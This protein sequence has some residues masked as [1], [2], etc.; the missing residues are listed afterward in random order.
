MLKNTYCVSL[1]PAL[2]PAPPVTSS[3]NHFYLFLSV[4][5]HRLFML[6]IQIIFPSFY[7][8]SSIILIPF[9]ALLFSLKVCLLETFPA[10]VKAECYASMYYA[11]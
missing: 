8:K 10:F 4:S 6:E 3:D 1:P 2:R 11:V 9:A 7:T 5:S